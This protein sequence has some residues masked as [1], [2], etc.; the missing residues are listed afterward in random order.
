MLTTI[1]TP[2]VYRLR[3]STV[4]DSVGDPVLSWASPQRSPIPRAQVQETPGAVAITV[5]VREE[6]E[7][8]LLIVGRADLT[9]ADRIEANGHVWRFETA[10]TARPSLASGVLTEALLKRIE[11]TP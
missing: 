10:P 4:L 2:T 3:P 9:A 11:V 5:G 7:A 8:V 1:A 6:G